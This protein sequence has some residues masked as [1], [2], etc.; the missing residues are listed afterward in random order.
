M[1]ISDWSSDVCSSD[2]HSTNPKFTSPHATPHTTRPQVML[3]WRPRISARMPLT[4]CG[5]SS[6]GAP[7]CF[8]S[9]CSI[10][11]AL[12]ENLRSTARACDSSRSEEHT[13]EL[14]SLLRTSYA[15]FCLQKKSQPTQESHLTYNPPPNRTYNATR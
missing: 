10:V 11:D 13:S 8:G 1:R 14:P 7:G 15:A 9:S 2:L 4:T 3:A 12:P 5:S 6:A